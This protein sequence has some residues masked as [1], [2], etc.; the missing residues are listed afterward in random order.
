MSELEAF[1]TGVADAIREK[2]GTSEAIPAQSFASEIREIEGGV[3]LQPL[4]FTG[5]VEATYDGKTP[6]TV[7]IPQSGGNV[8]VYKDNRTLEQNVK[9]F[10]VQLPCTVDKLIMWNMIIVIPTYEENTGTAF[11]LYVRASGNAN[12]SN[13]PTAGSLNVSAIRYGSNMRV[14][15]T[16]RKDSYYEHT[17]PFI[18]NTG[19]GG[20]PAYGDTISTINFSTPTEGFVFPSGTRYIFWGVYGV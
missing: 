4:T 7:E 6:V 10:S 2:K 14:A 3:D 12:I 9:G 18:F 15:V 19:S 5:A 17:L 13:M 20:M 8:S 11:N 1:L 16:T